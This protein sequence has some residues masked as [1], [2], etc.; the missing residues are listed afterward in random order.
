MAVNKTPLIEMYREVIEVTDAK[1]LFVAWTGSFPLKGSDSKRFLT[2]VI[3][4]QTI[5]C[6]EAASSLGS[7]HFLLQPS[8]QQ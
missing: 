5:P 7:K 6:A 1:N 4:M 3:K 8:K 2:D